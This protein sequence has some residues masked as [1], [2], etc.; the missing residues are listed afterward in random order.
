MYRAGLWL[1]VQLFTWVPWQE[2]SRYSVVKFSS[3]KQFLNVVISCYCT[4]SAG[5]S[6]MFKDRRAFNSASSRRCYSSNNNNNNNNNNTYS[7]VL[8]LYLSV[9]ETSYCYTSP[10]KNGGT[11]TETDTGF[12]CICPSKWNCIDCSC[13]GKSGHSLQQSQV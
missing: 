11:C 6:N 2:M 3:S 12:E 7:T 5:K 10:C 4:A 9:T 13:S 1:P 8:F